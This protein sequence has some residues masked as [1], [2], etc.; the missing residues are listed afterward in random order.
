MTSPDN[1]ATNWRDLADQLTTEQRERIE[2]MERAYVHGSAGE[3]AELLLGVAR[4]HAGDNLADTMRFG[5]VARPVGATYVWHW[6]QD[7]SGRWAREFEGTARK[8]AGFDV[9]IDGRQ[10]ADGSVVRTIGV[11]GDNRAELDPDGARRF[12]A[13]LLSAADE[14]GSLG[15]G[16][17]NCASWDSCPR[18]PKARK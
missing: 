14:V 8:V 11:Q 10:Y 12:A 7:D 15:A 16:C 5:H 9:S 2:E 1:T 4:E 6:E 18:H 3:V 13:E 17:T